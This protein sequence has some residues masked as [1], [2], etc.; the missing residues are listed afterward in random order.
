MGSKATNHYGQFSRDLDLIKSFQKVVYFTVATSCDLRENSKLITALFSIILTLT[1]PLQS[2]FILT[3]PPSAWLSATIKNYFIARDRQLKNEIYRTV[4]IIM[5]SRSSL[6][7][8]PLYSFFNSSEIED[9]VNNIRFL[10]DGAAGCS[11]L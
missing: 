8:N 7:I 9:I 6:V 2:R 5:R 10:R 1:L 4:V 3:T 11:C